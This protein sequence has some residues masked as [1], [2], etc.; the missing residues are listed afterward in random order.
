[1]GSNY[2]YFAIFNFLPIGTVAGYLKKPSA[3]AS[4]AVVASPKD[5]VSIA[6][7][8]LRMNRA[9]IQAQGLDSGWQVLMI[10]ILLALLPLA[11]LTS[12]PTEGHAFPIQKNQ[13]LSKV[14]KE[15]KQLCIGGKPKGTRDF[16]A[17]EA[18]QITK[19]VKEVEKLEAE[20][21]IQEAAARYAIVT[22][23]FYSIEGSCGLNY[24][25]SKILLGSKE[26]RAFM[27]GEAERNIKEGLY[28]TKVI[29]AASKEVCDEHLGGLEFLDE[30]Y[31]KKSDNVSMWQAFTSSWP[32]AKKCL[33]EYREATA[34][35]LFIVFLRLS[36]NVFEGYGKEGKKEIG[37]QREKLAFEM[38]NKAYQ[39]TEGNPTPLQFAGLL[40]KEGYFKYIIAG[41]EK[42]KSQTYLLRAKEATTQAR[43]IYLEANESEGA[44]ASALQLAYILEMQEN[45]QDA[46]TIYSNL[47]SEMAQKPLLAINLSTDYNLL[48]GYA[49][50]SKNWKNEKN[51]RTALRNIRQWEYLAMTT[52]LPEVS[53]K[54]RLVYLGLFSQSEKVASRAL[55]TGLIGAEEYLDSFLQLRYMLIDSELQAIKLGNQKLYAE[56]QADPQSKLESRLS[57]APID[58][59]EKIQKSLGSEATFIQYVEASPD[60][61]SDS[62]LNSEITKLNQAF[63]VLG[64][65]SD[66]SVKSY[67]LCERK[68]CD[69]LLSRAFS[70]TSQNLSDAG[71]LWQELMGLVLPDPLLDQVRSHKKIFIGLDGTLQR[72]PMGIVRQYLLSKG[73]AGK[74]IVLVQNLS[75]FDSNSRTLSSSMPVVFYSP[76]FGSGPACRTENQCPIKWS[77]L[78]HSIPEGEEVA[79]IVNAFSYSGK[80][81]SKAAITS[82]NDPKI[83]HLSTHAGY[84]DD[85]AHVGGAISQAQSNGA[86]ILDGLYNLYI[87]ASGANI[88]PTEDTVL[89]YRDLAKINLATTDLVVLS[90]CETGLGGSPRGYGLFGLHRILSSIG[91]KTTLL[92][93]WKVDDEATSVFIGLFYRNLKNGMRVDIALERAQDEMMHNIE[94]VRRGWSKQYYWAGWQV[95]GNLEPLY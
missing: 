20:G 64:V 61:Y 90:A 55:M 82:V 49:L 66:Q 71:D 14:D 38:L 63:V 72:I 24:A 54:D 7:L 41:M 69:E 74:Q 68:R 19:I 22:Q 88:L 26:Y 65:K 89:S 12:F 6:R 13:A 47:I 2:A 17:K 85:K 48:S 25:R 78:P 95:S 84:I 27:F 79:R 10:R 52:I 5:L 3:R 53:S 33:E 21:R 62:K 86:A 9:R 57:S 45:F 29:G 37:S 39:V 46:D 43:N 16:T 18:E 87:I 40:L 58:Y 50:L 93:M 23:N 31:Q 1:M 8:V 80:N 59:V 91:A 51:F 56:S 70:S 73:L 30:I 35:R 92:S 60:V 44:K 83:M 32:F 42:N 77:S 67:S 4:Y 11:L 36:S 76:D 94:Y 15:K 34:P 81:A 28:M 75:D